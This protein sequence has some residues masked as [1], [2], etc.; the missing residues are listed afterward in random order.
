MVTLKALASPRKSAIRISNAFASGDS[1]DDAA[2]VGFS[3]QSA[4][5]G[6]AKPATNTITRDGRYRNM[7]LCLSVRLVRIN[8]PRL[9][10]PGRRR[11]PSPRPATSLRL[12]NQRRLP[13][14]RRHRER[15]YPLREPRRLPDAR[16]SLS[17]RRLI[18]NKP[19]RP[20]PDKEPEPKLRKKPNGTCCLLLDAQ[21]LTHMNGERLTWV[22]TTLAF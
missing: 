21:I 4:A 12:V 15:P 1:G 11:W 6:P 10:S 20:R 22:D 16:R 13:E 19:R 9:D 5:G 17:A 8:G 2:A 18:C 3:S 7:G 14:Q